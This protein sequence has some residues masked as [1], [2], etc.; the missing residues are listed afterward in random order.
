MK[1]LKLWEED[2]EQEIDRKIKTIKKLSEQGIVSERFSRYL[3]QLSLLEESMERAI[4]SCGA[5]GLEDTVKALE[6]M[7][8]C[9]NKL[10]EIQDLPE[11][12]QDLINIAKE[13]YKQ[14]NSKCLELIDEGV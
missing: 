1:G 14:T 9:Y 3:I 10:C 2:T 6:E 8:L 11:H 4:E 5:I 13:R 12:Y 7:D